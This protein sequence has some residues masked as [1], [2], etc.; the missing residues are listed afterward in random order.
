MNVVSFRENF[1]DLRVDLVI[2]LPQLLECISNYMFS[3][4]FDCQVELNIEN[5]GTRIIKFV[6]VAIFSTTAVQ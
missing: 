6:L 5:R 4:F 3:C 1:S 2:S